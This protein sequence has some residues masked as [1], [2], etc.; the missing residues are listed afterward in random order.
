MPIAECCKGHTLTLDDRLIPALLFPASATEDG[1]LNALPQLF[2]SVCRDMYGV[3][4]NP[5]KTR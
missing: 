4:I 2:Q 5:A 1:V 3:N